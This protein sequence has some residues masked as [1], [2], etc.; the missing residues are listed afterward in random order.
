VEYRELGKT[1]EKVSTI[2]MGT[3]KIGSYS[4]SE[5]RTRQLGALK[6][7][8]ELG[9]NLVDTAEMY[10]AG[11]SEELVAEAIK[12]IRKDI[13]IASKVSPENLHHD[14][15]IR[16]C[17]ASLHRLGTPYLDLYQIHWPNPRIPIEETM[18]A[19][20]ELVD[21]GAVRFVG[22][23]NFSV[24]E[25]E[26]ARAALSRSDVVSNQVEYSLT[27][28]RVE[29]DVL[30]Y[31]VRENISL[32][33]YSPLARGNIADSIPPTILH[34]Y[35]MTSAQVMLNWATRDP[36]VIAIPKAAK[37][38]HLEENASSVSVRFEPAEYEQI[39]QD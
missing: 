8:F 18:S 31:C 32:I 1:G 21:A 20:G 37:A 39:G 28:R 38:S 15:V 30:P 29:R 34:K 12:G 23:S 16:A 7:G 36:H 2:G 24:S 33:A 22:V 25:T 17:R 3:W 11:R 5:E 35:K 13:L 27:N 6:R 14:E 4:T 9:V 10:G 19:M 26:Q